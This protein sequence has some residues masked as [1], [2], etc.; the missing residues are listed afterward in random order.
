MRTLVTSL[1]VVAGIGAGGT[2]VA[3]CGADDAVGLDVAKAAAATAEKG[4]AR[5]AVKVSVAGAGLPLP[6][7]VNAQ[8]V[9][10]L[11][12]PKGKL[13]FDLK[14]LLGLAPASRR[15]PPAPSR[16]ASTAAASTPSR[17]SSTS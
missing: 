9:T 2:A 6:V 3:G 11:D 12:A 5:V 13:T 16:C 7:D 15:A 1:C 4:T 14:P 17:R 10:A 8:G